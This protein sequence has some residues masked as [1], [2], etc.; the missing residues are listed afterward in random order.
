MSRHDTVRPAGRRKTAIIAVVLA[1]ATTIAVPTMSR[2][3]ANAAPLPN[4][5]ADCTAKSPALRSC[6]YV[7]VQFKANSPGANERVSSVLSNCGNDLVSTKVFTWTAN[8]LRV[9]WS[10]DGHMFD[11]GTSLDASIIEVGQKHASVDI[12]IDGDRT[13]VGMSSSLKGRVLPNHEGFVMFQPLRLDSSGYVRAS[14][15]TPI[16][17]Q[18]EFFLPEKSATTVHVYYPQLLSENRPDGT[19][20][21][22]N[23][24]CPPPGGGVLSPADEGG[25]AGEPA[26]GAVSTEAETA[27]LNSLA[28]VTDEVVEY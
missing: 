11:G 26:P 25:G 10:E 6:D 15:R 12:K 13:S 7:E 8:I 2:G 22:R 4:V 20:W 1:V 9:V 23:R 27:G 5:A 24:P 28:G 18:T 17:G 21:L 3:L 19:L 14:Y 16:E